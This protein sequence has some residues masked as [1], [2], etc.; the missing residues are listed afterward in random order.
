MW[1]KSQKFHITLGG[2]EPGIWGSTMTLLTTQV[3]H[4][5]TIQANEATYYRFIFSTR[6]LDMLTPK[7]LNDR[8]AQRL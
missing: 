7:K 4:G 8:L 1:A 3:C 2:F 5:A 6:M